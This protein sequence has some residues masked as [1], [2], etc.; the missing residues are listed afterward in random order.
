MSCLL[1][2]NYDSY[3]HILYQYLW[4]L[5]GQ[6]PLFRTHDQ[7]DFEE[8]GRLDITSIVISPGP[9]HPSRHEDFG[10]CAEL[11]RRNSNTPILGVCL[12]MQGLAWVAGAEVGASPKVMHGKYSQVHYTDHFLFS[13]LPN[14]FR[15]VRYHSLV[16]NQHNLPASIRVIAHAEDDGQIMAIEMSGKP[17]WGL[18][19]H[20]E[21]IGTQGGKQILKNFLFHCDLIEN[22]NAIIAQKSNGAWDDTPNTKAEINIEKKF[23]GQSKG[24]IATDLARVK[25]RVNWNRQAETSENPESLFD[26]QFRSWPCHVWLDYQGSSAG[27]HDQASVTTSALTKSSKSSIMASGRQ[28]WEFNKDSSQLITWQQTKTRLLNKLTS[29]SLKGF[30]K[31]GNSD[32]FSAMGAWIESLDIEWLNGKPPPELD[33]KPGLLGYWAYECRHWAFG[34]RDEISNQWEDWPLACFLIPEQMAFYKVYDEPFKSPNESITELYWLE[35]NWEGIEP[36]PS[37]T[38]ESRKSHRAASAPDSP[39][40]LYTSDISYAIPDRNR[41]QSQFAA[42]KQHLK[43]G[44]IYQACLCTELKI[45]AQFEPWK[46]YQI[47]RQSNPAPYNAYYRLPYGHIASASPECFL[48]L[49]TNGRLESRPIKG[50]RPRGSNELEDKALRDELH[51]GKKEHSENLMILDLIRN[52]FG[53]VCERGTV[54]VPQQMVVE[55]H[56]TVYQLVSTVVGHLR[57]DSSAW[58]VLQACFPGGSMTGAPKLRAMKILAELENQP[59]G[60]YSGAMGFHGLDGSM[61]LAMSIR[62]LVECEAYWSLSCG[63]AILAESEM[64]AEFQETLW[65]A[66]GSIRALELCVKSSFDQQAWEK[67]IKKPDE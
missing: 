32:P 14:P 8:L 20:P 30:W 21:S 22:A 17:H 26:K 10:N 29:H 6:K 39:A 35:L 33:I 61:E 2:D 5:S 34:S 46:L 16:I 53:R 28:T 27:R 43:A 45:E 52:D 15:A 50:T 57:S 41:Y 67:K 62:S 7:I 60:I 58:N 40:S 36:S 66:F 59:R 18:Q 23:Q 55:A 11:I 31:K 51:N 25:L 24:Q 44:N 56:P 13:A 54:Q 19:F 63:G 37:V 65:K 4:E 9:G 3:T 42:L 1:I 48:S 64:E 47:L 38:L 12:G 49:D